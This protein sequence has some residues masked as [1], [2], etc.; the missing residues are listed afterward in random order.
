MLKLSYAVTPL[1]FNQ[2]FGASPDYYAKF[3]DNHGNP[4][5]GH[6]GIDFMSAHGNKLYAPCDGSA[7]YAVDAHGGD[8]IYIH[9]SDDEGNWYNVILWHLCSKDDPQFAPLIPT[10]GS[11]VYVKKGQH[12]G[13]TDNTGAPYESSGDHLHFGLVKV[14]QD[15][16]TTLNDDNGFNGCIDPKPF[17]DGNFAND[18]VPAIV[19][20]TS[21]VISEVAALPKDQQSQYIGPLKGIVDN[22]VAFL[23]KR[24]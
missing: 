2:F 7:R 16:T 9:T 18:P 22:L 11:S 24:G 4:L 19:A 12:I 20:T 17:F 5:K 21:T 3:H 23:K 15:N 1:G 8:G 6:N 14:T 10:D 13:Y